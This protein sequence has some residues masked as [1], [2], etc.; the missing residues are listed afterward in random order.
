MENEN[1]ANLRNLT[2]GRITRLNLPENFWNWISHRGCTKGKN[3]NFLY[4]KIF[5]I[6]A[7]V[8][9]HTCIKY[10]CS[11]R[12]IVETDCVF[13]ATKHFSSRVING[14]ARY[15]MRLLLQACSQT[16]TNVSLVS[17]YSRCR[18]IKYWGCASGK[19]LPLLRQID[20]CLKKLVRRE[21]YQVLFKFRSIILRS[22]TVKVQNWALRTRA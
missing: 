12:R 5:S 7:F 11:I 14:I 1:F 16:D 6:N 17:T 3:S 21:I 2:I 20:W 9:G 18:P 13:A 22:N 4:Y 19:C 15:F 10:K 8:K